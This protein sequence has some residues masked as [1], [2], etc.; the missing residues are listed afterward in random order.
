VVIATAAQGELVTEKSGILNIGIQGTLTLSAFAA[1]VANHFL[2]PTLGAASPVGG[3]VA[4]IG[5]GILVNFVF[6][7]LSTKVN[8][9]QVIAGIG[10]NILAGGLTEIILKLRFTLDGTP[11][12]NSLPPLF[13]IRGLSSGTSLSIS[14]LVIIMFILPG[15]TYFILFRTKLGLHIRAVGENP[16]AAEVAGLSVAR[17]RIL[18]T[19][20]GGAF[21]GLAG[22]Y[23]TVDLFNL[24]DPGVYFNGFGFIALAAVIAG[25]WGAIYVLGVALIF[26]TSV[27]LIYTVQATTGPVFYLLSVLPYLMTV[28]VL[29]IASKRLR[30]PTALATPYKKE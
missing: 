20:L 9:D 29:A 14:P 2:E 17:T 26:G 21:I 25:A 22:S 23:L 28:A 3:I 5:T 27:G 19:S 6:S 15:I 30:P 11:I 4:G 10:I 18:A 13:T 16:K 8:V 24:Y 7:V 1:A 12:A